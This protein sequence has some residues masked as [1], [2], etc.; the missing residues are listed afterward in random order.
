MLWKLFQDLLVASLF[1]S[2]L[3]AQR[4]MRFKECHPVSKPELP[5]VFNHPLWSAWDYTLDFCLNQIQESHLLSH[6]KIWALTKE[7]FLVRSSLPY[8]S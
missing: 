4:L 6:P 5:L 3:L 7:L 2:F 1:R 8:N